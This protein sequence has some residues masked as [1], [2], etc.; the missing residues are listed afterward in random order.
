MQFSL[1]TL[2][3][4]MTAVAVVLAASH[5]LGVEVFEFASVFCSVAVPIAL[6]SAAVYSRGRWRTFFGGATAAALID[7]S[8]AGYRAPLQQFA[9]LAIYALCGLVALGVR[10]FVESWGIDQ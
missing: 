8:R 7:F 3:V 9:M 1:R 5:F 4:L 10:R 6:G 2:L